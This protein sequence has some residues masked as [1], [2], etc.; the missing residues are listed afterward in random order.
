M[1]YWEY[2]EIFKNTYLEKQLQMAGSVHSISKLEKWEMENSWNIRSS[3]SEVLK[4][5]L[6][7]NILSDSKKMYLLKFVTI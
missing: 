4:K 7:L 5:M 2:C 1:F 6:I 3:P